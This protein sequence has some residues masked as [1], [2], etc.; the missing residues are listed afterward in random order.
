MKIEDTYQEIVGKLRSLQQQRLLENQEDEEQI[1]R[2]LGRSTGREVREIS[3]SP[4]AKVKVEPTGRKLSSVTVGPKL[5]W[6]AEKQSSLLKIVREELGGDHNLSR[7]IRTFII[8][9]DAGDTYTC[10]KLMRLIG[11][12]SG[13]QEVLDRTVRSTIWLVS[14]EL[15]EKHLVVKTKSG[16]GAGMEAEWKRTE[17][18]AVTVSE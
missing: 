10:G 16:G 8:H 15:T 18:E 6:P 14:K 13:F 9:L 7:A 3:P 2:Y 5:D 1:Q 4:S 11:R 12:L 17:N